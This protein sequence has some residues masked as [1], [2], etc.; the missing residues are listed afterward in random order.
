MKISLTL[1]IL[2]LLLT[3]LA[4]APATDSERTRTTSS[5]P[6]QESPFRN[7]D[8]IFQTS[9]SSQSEAI[10][11]ATNSPYSHMGILY[12]D[13]GQWF[14]YEA[15]QPVKLTPLEAWIRRGVDQH[16]VVK[17]L[18]NAAEVLSPEVLK[19]MRAVGQKYEGKDYDIYFG[20]S[21][22]KIYCSELVWKIYQEA[23]GIEIGELEELSDFDLS[24]EPVQQKMRERYGDDIPWDEPVI[25]PAA[26]F[27]A[28]NLVTV[29]EG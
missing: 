25:S 4:C 1:P 7:G 2:I 15:V 12:Q 17:R 23:A 27:D 22:E 26:M 18:E 20:W 10:Q 14:V 6:A 29:A 16:Y 28:R 3:G 21:D 24:S 8:I 5:T 19:R 13:N 9:K 11:L